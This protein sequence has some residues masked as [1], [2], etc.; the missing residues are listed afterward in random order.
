MEEPVFNVAGGVADAD[1]SVNVVRMLHKT[2]RYSVCVY[3]TRVTLSAPRVLEGHVST[4]YTS[5]CK[6]EHTVF[7]VW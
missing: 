5:C 4:T 1:V 2:V 3:A 7:H 6:K